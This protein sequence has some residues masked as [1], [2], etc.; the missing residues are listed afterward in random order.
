ME[1]KSGGL[2]EKTISSNLKSRIH[3]SEDTTNKDPEICS[4][5]LA[6][7][8]NQEKISILDCGHEYHTDCIK[9]WLMKR[10]VCDFCRASPALRKAIK[11]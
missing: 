9:Q 5:C 6:E 11:I 8:E 2:S 3:T 7:Y 1:A 10:N 4:I